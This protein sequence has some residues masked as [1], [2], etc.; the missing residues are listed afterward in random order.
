MTLY[1]FDLPTWRTSQQRE[2]WRQ[3]ICRCIP[4]WGAKGCHV[5]CGKYKRWRMRQT[6]AF[7]QSLQWFCWH[8]ISE[9]VRVLY[10]TCLPWSPPRLCGRNQGNKC[11][12]IFGPPGLGRGPRQWWRRPCHWMD[13]DILPRP[14]FWCMFV[15]GSGLGWKC[16]KFRTQCRD[17][18]K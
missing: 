18:N 11:S 6:F 4:C 13:P 7:L 12:E 15:R 2:K 1:G 8:S 3:K 9:R 17:L 10:L 5:K 14:W 16:K